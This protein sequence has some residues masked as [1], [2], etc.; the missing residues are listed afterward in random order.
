MAGDGRVS[1]RLW[2]DV[3]SVQLIPV[4]LSIDSKAKYCL[5]NPHYKLVCK[6]TISKQT[7]RKN[8]NEL[9]ENLDE[10]S[11]AEQALFF[12]LT[13][14]TID[15]AEALLAEAVIK[16]PNSVNLWNDLAAI[17]L[18]SAQS[19]SS[20]AKLERALS[21]NETALSISPNY[22]QALFNRALIYEALIL[23]DNALA[24]WEKAAHYSNETWSKAAKEKKQVLKQLNTNKMAKL[25]LQTT[26]NKVSEFI[27]GKGFTAS[28]LENPIQFCE[29]DNKITNNS[30]L[31]QAVTWSCE[32]IGDKSYSILLSLQQAM[33]AYESGSY[34]IAE[35]E[36]LSLYEKIPNESPLC[37]TAR[38]IHG[39]TMFASS[40]LEEAKAILQNNNIWQCENEIS[41]VHAARNA[42]FLGS[43]ALRQLK[44]GPA[45]DYYQEA[46]ELL[47]GE[48]ELEL[49][50]KAYALLADAHIAA[51]RPSLAWH[52]GKQALNVV[53]SMPNSPKLANICG[54]LA[55]IAAALD[56]PHV[57]FEYAKCFLTRL[58]LDAA[59]YLRAIAYIAVA[60]AKTPLFIDAQP[61]LEQAKK[62]I[63]E[64]NLGADIKAHF[65]YALGQNI[66]K[67]S[68]ELALVSL[69]RAQKVF[70]EQGNKEFE[71]LTKAKAL[72]LKQGDEDSGLRDT[73]TED[74]AIKASNVQATTQELN[75]HLS[76]ERRF[77]PI[78]EI[79]IT[80]YLDKQNYHKA[81]ISLLQARG[82]AFENM[83]KYIEFVAKKHKE[84]SAS[85]VLSYIDN[86]IS[87]WL[88]DGSGLKEAFV[89]PIE[90]LEI[91]VNNASNMSA[92]IGAYDRKKSL[93]SLYDATIRPIQ[94]YIEDYE[95]LYIV[96][97]DKLFG[98]P[99]PALRDEKQHK[100]LIEQTNVLISPEFSA[101]LQ[102][103]SAISKNT[104]KAIVI[105][106]SIADAS[107][108]LPFAS[109]E[110]S[111]VYSLLSDNYTTTL[112]Q[113][114]SVDRNRF[115][116]ALQSASIVHFSGHGEL[117]SEQPELSNLV[118]G[119]H[120]E[121]ALFAKHF[122]TLSNKVTAKLVTMAACDTAAFSDN[123]PHALALVRPLLDAGSGFVLGS[124]KPIGDRQYA[125]MMHNFYTSLAHENDVYKAF[126]YMQLKEIN[127]K[128]RGGP[129]SW[130]A[131]NLFSYI[132]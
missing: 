27:R 25:K 83:D 46:I 22:E 73:D 90:N 77:R 114:E 29:S 16:K 54:F 34:E 60:E 91:I 112:Y 31:R 49:L 113:G 101:S 44:I 88:I 47:K 55:D 126:R 67:L 30:F 129:S 92:N 131:V 84:K 65:E 71:L 103:D 107:R 120:P 35:K 86:V 94:S 63:E 57:Q 41:P 64:N 42:S 110:A 6:K 14:Y 72:S 81:F 124:L 89:S 38:S 106:A 24:Y 100:F 36:L 10:L 95:T 128:H 39:S 66:A 20:M 53:S 51:N 75:I 56:A 115:M 80:N 123:Q 79:R 40:R 121:S 7:W 11:L 23:N 82:I 98:V 2:K 108:T 125:R 85:L 96:P 21:A 58:Q 17:S 48:T 28:Y 19:D 32:N 93:I 78:H 33:L 8:L 104:D 59:P 132:K 62:I 5:D 52:W 18:F 105:D 70:E 127:A 130:A 4:R 9:A 109:K 102:N 118:F 99:F 43:I 97:D 116:D 87:V 50:A 37:E 12:S 74:L 26:E 45:I 13:D 76:L 1:D 3:G 61:E 119:A 117:N 15:S 122:Y 69:E 111:S 68:P